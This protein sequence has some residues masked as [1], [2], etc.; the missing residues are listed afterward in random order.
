MKFNLS[1]K[2]VKSFVLRI[3]KPQYN[4]RVK[5]FESEM[6]NYELLPDGTKVYH[7]EHRVPNMIIRHEPDGKLRIWERL[8]KENT[9]AT[10]YK[11]LPDG[12]DYK[13]LPDGTK[14]YYRYYEK[15][16]K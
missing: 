13:E 3:V 10:D 2:A 16:E 9:A 11:A 4:T 15:Y 12:T 8:K 1:W 7:V 14:V 6:L 5:T